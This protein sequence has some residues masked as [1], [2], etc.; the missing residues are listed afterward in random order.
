MTI[1]IS[2]RTLLIG[3]LGILLI[4]TT[5]VIMYVVTHTNDPQEINNFTYG[6]KIRWSDFFTTMKETHPKILLSELTTLLSSIS[7]LDVVPALIF[8]LGY[9]AYWTYMMNLILRSYGMTKSLPL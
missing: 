7:L 9:H 6:E 8:C 4:I 5:S 1:H 3:F 2:K